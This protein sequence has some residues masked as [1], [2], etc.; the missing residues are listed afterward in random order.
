MLEW[1]KSNFRNKI[2]WDYNITVVGHA[3]R[4]IFANVYYYR[5]TDKE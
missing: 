1:K 3:R 4:Q 5:L 2:M